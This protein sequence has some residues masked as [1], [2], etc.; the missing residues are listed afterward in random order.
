MTQLSDIRTEVLET[1]GLASDD[2]RFPSATLNRIINRA[3]RSV[4]AEHDWPW[5]QVQATVN[6][7]AS[8]A[9]SNL[10]SNTC[11]IIRLAID[12]DDLIPLSAREG[13]TYSQ[14]TGQPR[15][16]WVEQDKINWAPVPDGVYAVNAIYSKYED[17]LSGDSDTPNLPTRYTDWLVNTAL[18]Q[19]SQRIRD[20]DLYTMADRER[21]AWSRRA[22]DE[23]RRVAATARPKVRNGW[24]RV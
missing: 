12:N 18:V 11:K 22:A 2:S 1:A 15:A 24:G 20:N 7:V 14:D 8:T 9:T 4:S 6:T 13:A 10:P 3:L 17:A 5:N 19:V 16:Y 21:R 23:V